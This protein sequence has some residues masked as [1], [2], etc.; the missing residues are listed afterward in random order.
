MSMTILVMDDDAYMRELLGLH[1]CDAGYEVLLAED[2]IVAGHLLLERR[3]DL[4]VA[5]IEVPYLNGLELVRAMRNDP[6]LS[7]MPV[8]FVTSHEEHAGRARE[9]GAVGFLRKPVRA[10]DLLATVAQHVSRRKVAVA[11]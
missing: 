5:D 9:L 7:S 4:F 2:A 1:L 3:V 10:D 6:S 8:I 11:V